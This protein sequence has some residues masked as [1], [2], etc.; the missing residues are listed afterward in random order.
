MYRKAEE[1]EIICLS[2]DES[3][4]KTLFNKTCALLYIHGMSYHI[5]SEVPLYLV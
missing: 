2:L 3:G 1:L 5:N 4:F